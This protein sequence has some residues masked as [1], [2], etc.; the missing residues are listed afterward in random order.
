MSKKLLVPLIVAVLLWAMTACVGNN[1]IHKNDILLQTQIESVVESP[2]NEAE[3][4]EIEETEETEEAIETTT[5][6]N[7]ETEPEEE[8]ST[9]IYPLL[10]TEAGIVWRVPPILE[11]DRIDYCG[12]CGGFIDSQRRP[13]CSVTGFRLS[14]SGGGH[15]GGCPPPEFVYDR[16]RHMFGEP[17]VS[18]GYSRSYVGMHPFEEASE[19]FHHYLYGINIV[20]AVDSDMR[21]YRERNWLNWHLDDDAFLGEFA[22]MY[23]GEFVTD[24]IF[25]G[26]L[27]P[28]RLS[29]RVNNEW[30]FNAVVMSINGKWG[31]VDGYGN[32]IAPFIFY[33]IN[34]FGLSRAIAVYNNKYG[35]INRYGNVLVPF[36]FDYIYQ[37][38]IFSFS[39]NVVAVYNGRHGVVDEHGSIVIPFLF[40]HVFNIDNSTAFAMYNGKYGIIDVYQTIANAN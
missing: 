11:H 9:D 2:Q 4:E 28:G 26:G 7:E 27:C 14:D 29:N 12:Q 18:D 17:I 31:V 33:Q 21:I 34:Y 15:G 30:S 24:F 23:N 37:F 19:W 35:L 1:A 38:C 20:Q 25:D 40:E 5:E 22:V 8:S 16:T 3:K 13:I 39:S 36:L 32:S 6:A 10:V